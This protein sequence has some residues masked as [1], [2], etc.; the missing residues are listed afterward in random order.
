VLLCILLP[1]LIYLISGN[2]IPS[3]FVGYDC[4]DFLPITLESY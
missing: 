1:F 3:L 2:A 4:A